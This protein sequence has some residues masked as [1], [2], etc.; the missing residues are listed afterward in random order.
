MPNDT[1]PDE[2]QRVRTALRWGLLGSIA[3]VEMGA[4]TLAYDLMTLTD[5]TRETK[6]AAEAKE[7]QAQ[8]AQLNEQVR[9]PVLL[10]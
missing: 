7:A 3:M 1:E 10:C 4:L 8:Q 2:D 6:T 5:A 9:F